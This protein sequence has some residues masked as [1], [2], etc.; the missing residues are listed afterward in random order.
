MTSQFKNGKIVRA[1][2]LWDNT[3]IV[4]AMQEI[5]AKKKMPTDQK[6]MD[7]NLD[8]FLSKFLNEKDITALDRVLD[9]S[10][11]RYMNGE[12]VATG[13]KELGEGMS[14][15]FMKGFPDMKITNSERVYAGNKV[16]IHWGFKG[17]NTGEFNGIPPTGKKVVVS[18]LSEINF[19]SEG[20]LYLEK[21]YFN[22]SD[23]L[24]QLGY[25]VSP[26]KS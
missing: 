5:E 21:V 25:T 6:I 1:S 18:G 10:Y 2:G 11:V 9:K 14:T 23:L 3:P 19:N 15:T 7:Q 24:N 22:E 4:L 20:Q 12:K 8:L 17:T 16:F 13:A 26:P